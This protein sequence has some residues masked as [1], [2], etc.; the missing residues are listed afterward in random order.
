MDK[1]KYT[2]LWLQAVIISFLAGIDGIMFWQL[3]VKLN[4]SSIS[5]EA[6]A[7]L[8]ALIGAITTALGLAARDFFNPKD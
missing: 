2:Q 5:A 8:G 7:L 6:S 4:G 3:I 1:F